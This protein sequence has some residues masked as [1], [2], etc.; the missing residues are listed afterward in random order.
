MGMIVNLRKLEVVKFLAYLCKLWVATT[1]MHRVLTSQQCEAELFLSSV[2][3]LCSRVY[4][5]EG[6]NSDLVM[7]RSH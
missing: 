1:Y 7:A 3:E 5:Q 4:N 2:I 6:I